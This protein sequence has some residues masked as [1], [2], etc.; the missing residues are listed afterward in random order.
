MRRTR[1]VAAGLLLCS[2]WGTVA[3]GEQLE[4]FRIGDWYASS[5]SETGTKRISRCSALLT[6]NPANDPRT[7]VGVQ[8]NRDGTWTVGF[9][10]SRQYFGANE[11]VPIMLGGDG[12]EELRVVGTAIAP[13]LVQVTLTDAQLGRLNRETVVTI[14]TSQSLHVRPVPA[15]TEPK[16][17]LSDCMR[18]ALAAE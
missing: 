11:R 3:V 9:G 18:R 1:I 12:I 15:L 2:V 4:K 5:W 7:F 13:D 6:P 17:G 16:A 10:L 8:L 14:T